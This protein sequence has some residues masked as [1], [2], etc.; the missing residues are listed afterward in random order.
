MECIIERLLIN[1]FCWIKCFVFLGVCSFLST[2]LVII[3]KSV[4]LNSF[5]SVM[6]HDYRIQAALKVRAV[7]F[8]NHREMLL[9]K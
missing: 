3:D 9:K 7:F 4:L 2:S 1:P 8:V 5:T 6:S